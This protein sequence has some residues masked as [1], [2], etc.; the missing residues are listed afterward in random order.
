MLFGGAVVSALLGAVVGGVIGRKAGVEAAKT[1]DRLSQT[2]EEAAATALQ[3][4]IR[5]MLSVEIAQNLEML[6]VFM[7]T[8]AS[9]PNDQSGIEWM[10]A[11]PTP[12]WS[13]TVWQ[14]SI[15]HV[16][17]SVNEGDLRQIHAHYTQL[18]SLSSATEELRATSREASPNYHAL[19]QPLDAAKTFAENVIKI[20]NPIR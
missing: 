4:A 7:E 19:L 20:G 16:A 15:L 10:V 11:N 14:A 5:G 2:R 9:Q 1:A 3:K 6:A 18:S 13:T 12:H 17:S 8:L